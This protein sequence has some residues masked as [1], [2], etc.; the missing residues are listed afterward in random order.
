MSTPPIIYE[1]FWLWD[2]TIFELGTIM[3]YLLLSC[4]RG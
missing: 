2:K 1:R 3:H 4:E